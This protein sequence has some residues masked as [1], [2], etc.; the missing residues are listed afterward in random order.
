MIPI[1]TNLSRTDRLAEPLL[2]QRAIRAWGKARYVHG[3]VRDARSLGVAVRKL[4]YDRL[5]SGVSTNGGGLSADGGG[6]SVL[7]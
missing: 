5:A 4:P 6:Y 7:A 3:E 1:A 2:L